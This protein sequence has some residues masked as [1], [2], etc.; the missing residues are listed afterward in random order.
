MVPAPL[1][2][3]DTVYTLPSPHP[4]AFPRTTTG[5]AGGTSLLSAFIH[6]ALEI[7]EQAAVAAA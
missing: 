4:V 2:L 1:A 5:L 6:A 3:V 7:L